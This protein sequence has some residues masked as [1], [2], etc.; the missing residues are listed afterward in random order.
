MLP[1]GVAAFASEEEVAQRAALVLRAAY[2]EH[3]R[4]MLG[5]FYFEFCDE[6]WKARAQTSRSLTT[7]CQLSGEEG[8]GEGGRGV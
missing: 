6:W 5:T 2:L 8:G 4:L 7:R 3:S 1:V